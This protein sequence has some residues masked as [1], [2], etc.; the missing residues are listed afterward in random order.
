M[1]KR[2]ILITLLSRLMLFSQKIILGLALL[3]NGRVLA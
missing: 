1:I 3:V 2:F